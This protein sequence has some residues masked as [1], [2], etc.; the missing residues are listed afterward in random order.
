[1]LWRLV[2][3]WL[4]VFPQAHLHSTGPSQREPSSKDRAQTP[5][6]LKLLVSL[7]KQLRPVFQ[8]V[9]THLIAQLAVRLP[10]R[11]PEVKKRKF[12]EYPSIARNDE[13]ARLDNFAV[14]LQSDPTATGYI[15]V[16][17]G[18]SGKQGDVQRH[19][20]RQVDYLVNSRG[21]D[22]RRIVTLTGRTRDEL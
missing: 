8:W 14:E 11:L 4:G 20:T 12:D 22:A 2:R 16:Y 15:I 10:P 19:M 5:S 21:I 6:R 17:A 9:A 7:A 13:K 1:N 18:R 3:E